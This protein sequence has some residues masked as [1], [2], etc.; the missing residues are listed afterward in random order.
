MSTTRAARRSGPGT[1]TARGP[2]RRPARRDDEFGDVPADDT[3]VD[4]EPFDRDDDPADGY[5][6]EA[7]DEADDDQFD[8]RPAHDEPA[9]DE[10]AGGGRELPA[11]AAA[12][13][14]LR[15]VAE[16][17]G[18]QPTGVTSLERRDDGWLVGIEVV[19]DRRVPSSS[20]VLATYQAELGADGD[21]RGYRRTGR[22]ARGR[23]DSGAGGGT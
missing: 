6:D 18:K 8:D 21:L 4:D 16:L 10:P 7:D 9:H 22:Y 19:E 1:R 17:T 3:G 5:A 12:R 20:D 2:D 11:H 23:G 13:V 15:H 14:A